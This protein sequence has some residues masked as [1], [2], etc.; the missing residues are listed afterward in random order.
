MKVFVKQDKITIFGRRYVVYQD[1][2]KLFT[3]QRL[4]LTPIP[5]YV[6]T[7]YSSG[8]RIGRIQNKFLTLRGNAV[9]SIPNGNFKFEQESINSMKY[10]CKVIGK[11]TDNYDLKGHKGFTGSIYKNKEQIGQWNKNQFVIFDGDAYEIDLDFDSDILLIASM[12]VLV[13][14]YRISVTVGGDIGWEIGNIGKELQKENTNWSP[15]EN[16]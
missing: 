16:N 12:M 8:E 3:I 14:T 9:I 13:D 10:T 7:E 5:K 15:K 1:K 4:W 2:K 6:I 11:E